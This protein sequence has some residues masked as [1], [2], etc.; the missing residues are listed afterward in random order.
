MILIVGGSPCQGNSVLNRTR[1]SRVAW[2]SALSS[3]ILENVQNAPACFQEA[4]S[5]TFAIGP[6]LTCAKDFGHVS[7][8]RAWWAESSVPI[9]L[10]AKF[11]QVCLEYKPDGVSLQWQGKKCPKQVAFDAGFQKL[12]EAPLPCFTRCF[13]HPCDRLKSCDPDTQDRFFSDGRRFAPH[14]YKPEALLW[15]ER[16]VVE[17]SL[18][19]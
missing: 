9:A 1:E 19:S 14:S 6:L 10:P 15:K 8:P 13:W 11:P 2:P 12:T 4:A 16:R 17:S 3:A 18:C 7:R 5:G